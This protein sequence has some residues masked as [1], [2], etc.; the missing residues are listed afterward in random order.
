MIKLLLLLLLLLTTK[1]LLCLVFYPKNVGAFHHLLIQDKQGL[2]TFPT[3]D[4]KIW[5]F[6]FELKFLVKMMCKQQI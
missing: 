6:K 4:Q 2:L 5:V 3:D 1:D